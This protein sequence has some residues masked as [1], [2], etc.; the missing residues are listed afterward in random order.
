MKKKHIRRFQNL[1]NIYNHKIIPFKLDDNDSK[2]NKNLKKEIDDLNNELISIYS[3]NTYTKEPKK[4]IS[5]YKQICIEINSYIYTTVP[6]EAP[7]FE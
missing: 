1:S 7:Y 6:L 4:I 5:N 2:E 3:L